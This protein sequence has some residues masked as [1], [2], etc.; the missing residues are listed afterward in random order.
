MASSYATFG[1]WVRPSSCQ[2]LDVTMASGDDCKVPAKCFGAL[3]ISRFEVMAHQLLD[4][5]FILAFYKDWVL[6]WFPHEE[7][8]HT[9]GPDMS[10]CHPLIVPYDVKWACF[11]GNKFEGS[12]GTP[13]KPQLTHKLEP[14]HSPLIQGVNLVAILTRIIYSDWQHLFPSLVTGDPF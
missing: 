2:L 4:Y 13:A 11:G 14:P 9:V 1:G 8:S 5:D 3:L 7:L 12:V 10:V 6:S